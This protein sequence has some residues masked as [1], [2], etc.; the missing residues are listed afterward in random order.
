MMGSAPTSMVLYFQAGF[1]V[2]GSVPV[3][4]YCT[5]TDLPPQVP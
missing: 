5:G 4:E 3:M 1:A 2:N